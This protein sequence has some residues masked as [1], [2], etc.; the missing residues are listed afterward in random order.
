MKTSG[1]PRPTLLHTHPSTV[2]QGPGRRRV[3]HGLVP[4]ADDEGANGSSSLAFDTTRVGPGN[5]THCGSGGPHRL[6]KLESDRAVRR[7]EVDRL[8]PLRP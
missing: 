5:D 2:D 8:G 3:Q 4:V 6:Q 7:Q 1:Q